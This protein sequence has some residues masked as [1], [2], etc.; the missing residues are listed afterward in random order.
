MALLLSIDIG[1]SSA[2]AVLFDSDSAKILAIAGEEYP[3]HQ[4]TPD[5]TEQNPADWW[6][7]TISVVEKC[8]REAGRRDINAIGLTGQMHG[9]VP[10]GAHGEVLHPAIIWADSRSALETE[11]MIA[12]IG[13]ETYASIAGTLPAAGFM[14]PT[15]M[16]LMKHQRDLLD[17][18][19]TVLLPKDFV[20]SKLTGELATDKSDA[21][22]TGLFDVTGGTWSET[23]INALKL[24]P[25]IFPK[26]LDSAQIAGKLTSQAA[27]ALGLKAGIPVVAGCADQPA[28]ALANGLISSG[29][30]SLTI[31]T[32]GQV[33]VPIHLIA[34]QRVPADPRLHVFNHAVPENHYILGAILSAGLSLRWLRNLLGMQS[35]PQAYPTLS[36]EADRIQPGASGLIF[37][38]YLMGERT[39]HMD[40]LARGGFIGMRYYHQRGHLARAVMEGVAFAMRQ[41][42]DIAIELGGIEISE[43]IIAGGGA[44]SSVWRQIHTDVI[45]LPTRKTLL[46]EQTCIGAALLA[47][48]GI[49]AY[50]TYEQAS[51]AVVERDEPFEPDIKRHEQYNHLYEAFRDL[52][53]RLRDDFHN[54]AAFS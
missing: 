12:S 42:L 28:Q 54:L 51:Q 43:L 48:I 47:G 15:L 4:P 1:T 5:R 27:E 37:L 20:R 31:G 7:S 50:S 30:A 19:R 9:F 49:G 16:W 53:P 45:G 41:T 24:N 23:I 26:V 38:P 17:R 29:I 32:G 33:C 52:Y 2:K 21:A 46:K 6:L 34:G 36:A 11:E 22:A 14:G 40:A 39:P 10:L 35:D 25:S 18:T 44:E 3:L 13:A 8:V